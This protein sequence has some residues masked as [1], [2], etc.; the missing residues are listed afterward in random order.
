LYLCFLKAIEGTT[1]W[2]GRANFG[3]LKGLLWV[4]SSRSARPGLND[5]VAPTL[6]VSDV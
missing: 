5:K 3:P 6:A 1:R 2:I 4:D